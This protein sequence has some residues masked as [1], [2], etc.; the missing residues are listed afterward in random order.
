MIIWGSGV[1]DSGGKRLRGWG[2]GGCKRLGGRRLRR[3]RL[4]TKIV[5]EYVHILLRDFVAFYLTH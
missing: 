3:T 4:S 5:C 1:Q 2:G